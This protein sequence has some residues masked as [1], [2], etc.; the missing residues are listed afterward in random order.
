M[1]TAGELACQAGDALPALGRIQIQLYADMKGAALAQR[2]F[3]PDAAVHQLGQ[4]P[5]DGQSQPGAAEFSGGRTVG[6]GEGLEHV[7]DLFGAH[8]DALVAD[9][10]IQFDRLG[11]AAGDIDA[12]Q[13]IA[14]GRELD[15]I[16]RQIG[17]DLP[18]PERI[19]DQR[20]RHALRY[21]VGE[22]NAL[23]FGTQGD[24]QSNELKALSAVQGAIGERGHVNATSF[25]RVVLLTGEVPSEAD[26]QA[27]AK[28]VARI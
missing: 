9:G 7:G 15:R 23:L 2:T 19:T 1:P 4:M 26:K 25:N 16:G 17:Q 14:A 24:D 10:K 18:Q 22:F 13:Y 21:V 3:D 28:A 27:V 8:A 11:V 12:D 5:A 6:L 20:R